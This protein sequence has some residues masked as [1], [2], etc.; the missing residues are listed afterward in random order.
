MSVISDLYESEINVHISSFRAFGFLVKLGD[1]M[2]GFS[3]GAVVAT[4]DDLE[5]W[6][7]LR[8]VEHYPDS[9]FARRYRDRLGDYQPHAE[10]VRDLPASELANIEDPIMAMDWNTPGMPPRR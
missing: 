10:N 3:A 7:V 4:L 2:N 8:G 9:D 1:I 6:M 5:R